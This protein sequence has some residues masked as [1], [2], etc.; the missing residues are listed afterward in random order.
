MFGFV[1]KCFKTE[2]LDPID[3]PPSLVKTVQ[4]IQD[5]IYSFLKE[6]SKM[7]WKGCSVSLVDILESC[8]PDK[9]QPVNGQ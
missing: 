2:M 4:R 5:S 8:F 3:K 1:A 6:D 7:V 9:T